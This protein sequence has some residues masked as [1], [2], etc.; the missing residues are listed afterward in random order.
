MSQVSTLTFFRFGNLA[1]K[2]WAFGMMQFAHKHFAKVEGQEMYKLLGT[3]KEGFDPRPDFST[4]AILQIWENQ[5]KADA[6]FE[7]AKIFNTY[8]KKATEHYCVYLRNIMARGKWGGANPFKKSDALTDIPYYAVITRATIKPRFLWKFWRFVPKSRQHLKENDGLLLTKGVGEVPLKNMATFS[9]WSN[10]DA[11]NAF[12]Y[13]TKGHV[14]A[15]GMTRELGWYSEELFSRFQ[16]YKT[17]GSW[18]GKNP[19]KFT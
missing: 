13:Q 12:A 11:L 19:L 8:R 5:A 15:I 9:L 7:E 2:F 14:K 3:G 18:D 10:L 6:F 4:Y 16:P 17:I 1:S